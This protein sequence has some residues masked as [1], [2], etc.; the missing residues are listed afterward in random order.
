MKNIRRL[1][2]LLC[3]LVFLPLAAGAEEAQPSSAIETDVEVEDV[4]L[5]PADE[6]GAE[7]TL[8]SLVE[9][10]ESDELLLMPPRE[11]EFTHKAYRE[12]DSETLKYK[13]ETFN[14]RGVRCYLTKLWMQDPARQIR[15]VTSD[16]QQNTMY[17]KT[18][19]ET[20]PE[21]AL[22]INGSGYW[23]PVYQDVP[24]EYPGDVKDYFYT[25]WG[26]LTVT[27]GQVFR[28]LDLPYYGLTLEAEGLQIYNGV[29][30]AEVLTHHPLQTWAFRN[31]C[32]LQL[33][34]ETLI[35]QD[36]R[37]AQVKA[38]RTVIG[39]VDRNNYLILSVSAIGGLGMTLFEVNNFFL[40]H[41]PDL[42]WLYN[43]DGGP[44]TALIARKKG[45]K[46]MR[47]VLGGKAKDIDIMAFIEL[48]TEE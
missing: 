26:T 39:R 17:P 30:P 6:A 44:S 46:Q 25:P 9:E 32:V 5:S 11:Y 48:P 43:L 28:Q 24:E 35:P 13:M 1:G 3:L 37:F 47:K 40:K 22:A 4:Q 45:A 21:A 15:K 34:G 7:E 23:S 8:L 19:A 12:Y 10:A 42:E 2:A 36:W 20:I 33:H 41:F 18:M 27:D 16:W 14:S 31:Q 38:V 29:S